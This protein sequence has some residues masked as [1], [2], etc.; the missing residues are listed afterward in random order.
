MGNL[1]YG[2]YDSNLRAGDTF[3]F[4]RSDN[5]ALD[6][7]TLETIKS[8][9][10]DE[11]P[12]VTVGLS[13]SNAQYECTGSADQDTINT[14]IDY[15]ADNGGGIVWLLPGVY[16]TTNSI[17]L[18]SNVSLYGCG[19]GVSIIY[20]S[21]SDFTHIRTVLTGT[22]KDVY[23]NIF[24]QDFTVK[25]RRGHGIF[26][27][28][29]TNT[30]CKNI[31]VYFT[32]TTPI[33]ESL[34]FQHCKYVSYER[35]YLHDL[36]GNG[37]QINGCDY[38]VVMNNYVNGGPHADDLIDIDKDFV[39]TKTV[40]SNY[41]VVS[42]NTVRDSQAGD[43][44]RIGASNYIVVT[45]NVVSDCTVGGGAGILVNGYSDAQGSN[46]CSNVLVANNNIYNCVGDGI[47]VE[48]STG[49]CTNVRVYQ[50]SIKDC[51]QAGGSNVRAGIE[52]A[53]AG[54][55]RV[56]QNDLDNCGD[57][58][59]G[60]GAIVVYK[61]N[62][63]IIKN[64]NISNSDIGVKFWNA[65]G[66][67]S[68]TNVVLS[69]NN[70]ESVTTPYSTLS[71]VTSFKECFGNDGLNPNRTY[72]QGNITGATTFTRVN[73]STITATLTGSITVT[74]TDGVVAGDTLTL[75]LT[76]D[77]TGNWA[78]TWPSNFKKAGGTLTL[79]TAA[80]A[81]DVI[82]M[83]WDGTNWREVSRSLALS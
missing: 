70:M 15:A 8:Y 45:N 38:F 49:V 37:V 52:I 63:A 81:V 23:E 72:A 41:G 6:N 17:V 22:D 69:G 80:G 13:G 53:S 59:S 34:V 51:A 29:T 79:S 54:Y 47:R 12:F 42:N 18:K 1:V 61:K 48:D 35:A 78:A 50:N 73:G 21:T 43:G 20:G 33:K 36:T 31:E 25:S 28:N 11:T 58:T 56:E 3:G 83:S 74:L 82:E 39:D 32:V 71:A 2:N 77:G 27:N 75:I 57:N 26:I 7:A 24:I 76:Q 30:G 46:D 9:I 16:N 68:Y 60:Q 14:A 64:N 62:N 66:T 55:I 19:M 67:E 44:I 5:G 4:Q 40:Q 65:S 10:T